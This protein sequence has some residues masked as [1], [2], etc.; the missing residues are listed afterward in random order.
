MRTRASG[1]NRWWVVTQRL[2]LEGRFPWL[3]A[4][5]CAWEYGGWLAYRR[6]VG[7]AS[8]RP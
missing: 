3:G 1:G 6:S 8:C 5:V 2:L 7:E 4:P